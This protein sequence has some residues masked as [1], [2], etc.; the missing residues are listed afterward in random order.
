VVSV[1]D[2]AVTVRGK[3]G[4]FAEKSISFNADVAWSAPGVHI[5]VHQQW[6]GD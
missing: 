6:V 4:S 1:D 2:G 5:V 3:G